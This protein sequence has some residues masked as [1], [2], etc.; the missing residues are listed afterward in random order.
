[1]AFG[2]LSRQRR[3]EIGAA[4]AAA[5]PYLAANFAPLRSEDDFALAVRGDMPRE[6]RGVLYRN[7]PNPQFPPRGE[8][9]HWISGDGMVHQFTIEDGGVFYRN[10]WVRTDRW[11]AENT[12][13]RA[14]FGLWGNPMTSSLSVIGTDS[15]VA[16]TSIVY[17][18]GRLLALEEAHAPF[19]LDPRSLFPRGPVDFGGRMTAHPRIDPATGDMVFFAY[20]DDVFPLS[21]RISW[22]VVGADGVLKRRE[23]FR[24]PYCA[25]AH[26]FAVTEQHVLIPVLPL[27]GN[28]PR[29]LKRGPV[30]A[31]DPGK[32]A[33]I[34]VMRRDRGVASLRW[35]AVD[36]CYVF[37]FMNAYDT[38]DG[39]VA[40]VMKYD[41]PPLFPFVDGRPGVASQAHLVRWRFDMTGEDGQV[42]EQD[43]D[44]MAGEFPR[45]DER[46]T[47]LDY[48]HGWF[49][50]N[51]RGAH[52]MLTDCVV[53]VDCAAGKRDMLLLPPGDFVSEPVFVP[54]GPGAAEG[55][56]FLLAVV[57]RGRADV[58]EL[59]VLDAQDVAAGPLATAVLPRRV[60]YGFHGN[61]V[62]ASLLRQ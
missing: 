6:L 20:S 45:I 39:I 13:G 28:L 3:A 36:P 62:D 15:G 22:G 55:D 16:N 10:R 1:M 19:E 17:H 8:D 52:E 58:S 21:A 38:P 50:G 4:G 12:A 53:H 37:H 24:A 5:H 56:G 14:L 42:S 35:F 32:P 7:G 30:F 34:A 26:D 11:T 48:R 29:T 44:D 51:F 61:W 2:A 9:Y 23:S 33:L 31:W 60:P 54:R 57:Y 25:M 46:F 59:L 18:G 40:D 47:G 43:L 49:A 41:T 27:T